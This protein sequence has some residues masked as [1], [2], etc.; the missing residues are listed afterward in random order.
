MGEIKTL[1]HGLVPVY[2]SDDR[3]VV[4]AR[5]LHEFL[6]AG[7]DFSTWIK[8]RIQKYG[9]AEGE[10]YVLVFPDSGEN[11]DLTQGRGRPTK[12]YLLTL[13]VAK[14]LCMVENNERGRQARK[15]FIA[16][17]EELRKRQALGDFYDRIPKTYHEALRALADSEEENV[18]LVAKVQKDAPKVLFANSVETSHTSILIGDLAKILR[19]NGVDI[20]QNRLFQWLREKEFLIKGGGSKNMPTQKA[21]DMELFEVKERTINN[22]DGSVRIT[23]TTKVTG[24]GQVY[25]INKFLGTEAMAL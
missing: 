12:D 22:P 3:Q 7:K 23:K 10:D 11:S 13:N 14:E 25:F 1:H 15:Y 16:C 20:G 18:A 24:R 8:D 5:E 4:N 19:Q 17:E 2:E 9:F 21:M 6:G